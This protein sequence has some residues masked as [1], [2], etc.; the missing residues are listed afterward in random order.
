[1]TSLRDSVNYGDPFIITRISARGRRS[2]IM[3]TAGKDWNN[4]GGGSMSQVLYPMF[5][6]GNAELSFQ[7]GERGE[8]DLVGPG[9]R[10]ADRRRAVPAA[11]GSSW[12][13]WFMKPQGGRAGA[14]TSPSASQKSPRSGGQ[15]HLHHDEEQRRRAF[16]SPKLVD[17][18]AP[19]KAPIDRFRPCVQRGHQARREVAAPAATIWIGNWC[20]Q[21]RRRPSRP[22]W[23]RGCRTAMIVGRANDF[24]ESPWLF[25]I[26]CS[27]W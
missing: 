4:W 7:P 12:C 3:S 9:H 13:A 6:L 8:S 19:D 22:R 1:M 10:S 16:T 5:V 25:L 2:S 18:N 15:L 21:I 26:F 20:R 11:P 17:D 23:C 14:E 24:S 27:S